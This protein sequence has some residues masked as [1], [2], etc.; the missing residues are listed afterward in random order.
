VRNSGDA[1]LVIINDILDFSKV[2]AGKVE[3]DHVGFSVRSVVG[4][5]L[6][7]LAVSARA[8]GLGELMAVVDDA[9]P[10]RVVGDPGR[11]RQVLINLVGNAITFTPHGEIIVR[12][13]APEVMDD[14]TLVRF[15]ISDTGV[16]IAPEKLDLI[17]QPFAQAESSTSKN[18]GGTGL[19]LAISGQL[20]ALMGGECG[21][22]SVIER[23]S[24]F[25]FT[26]RVSTA[27]ELPL[28]SPLPL[29]N[30]PV[31]DPRQRDRHFRFSGRL[32]ILHADSSSPRTI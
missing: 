15:E 17:F 24:D 32:G 30:A 7:L 26:I 5:V 18:F 12:V 2:E 23:G 8:K 25:W 14:E 3:L 20:V 6:E 21:V 31:R 1:L 16:G 4:D 27:E 9:V 11:T 28:P 29:Q 13:T 10:N 19:G 22:S